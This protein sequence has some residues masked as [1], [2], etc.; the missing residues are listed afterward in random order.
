M[1]YIIIIF[2]AL[3]LIV[4]FAIFKINLK[5]KK[6][7]VFPKNWH[8]LLSENVKFYKKLQA[9]DQKIFQ[10][11]MMVFLNEVYIEGVKIEV[12]DLDKILVAASAVIPVFGFAEWHY[13]NLSSVLLYPD[14]FNENLQFDPE[15]ESRFI[16]GLVGSGQFK[17]Q[18]ILSKKALY[19]GFSNPSDAEN[20]AIHEFVHLIDKM[21]GMADGVPERLM[22]EPYIIPWLKLIHHEM[23]AINNN[24]SDI[25]K[26]GG[27]NEAEFLAVVSEYFF[28][29]PMKFED[30]HPELYKM[31]VACFQTTNK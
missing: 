13:P 24:K 15:N 16:S 1:T 2:S 18:M 22:K 27:T 19:A 14:N 11:R 31:L 9:E 5:K 8:Q 30:N 21:D 25:R 23:E 10:Q 29:R 17:N 6:I 26:Y 12:E 20:T 28:E 7:K 4:L 3:I